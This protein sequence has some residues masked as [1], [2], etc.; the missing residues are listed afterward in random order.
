MNCQKGDIAVI[1]SVDGHPRLKH[2][3]GRI[4]LCKQLTIA[5]DGHA[6]AYK[7]RR[8]RADGLVCTAVPDRWLRPLRDSDGK[9]EVLRLAGRPVGMPQAA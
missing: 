4:I 8:L 3:L 7:G 6:W 9:D 5:W 2:L 1:V